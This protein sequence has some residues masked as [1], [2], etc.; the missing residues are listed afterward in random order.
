MGCACCGLSLPAGLSLIPANHVTTWPHVASDTIW[1]KH[2]YAAELGVQGLAFAQAL[3]Y[4]QDIDY[5]PQNHNGMKRK[6]V[7]SSIARQKKVG[8]IKKEPVSYEAMTDLGIYQAA[9]KLV[10]GG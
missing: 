2:S 4:Y 6:S 7:E 3:K 1:L 10:D 8:N 9:L 5:F